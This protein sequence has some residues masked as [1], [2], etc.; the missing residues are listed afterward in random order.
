MTNWKTWPECVFFFFFFFLS[1]R[2]VKPG[3][4]T[5]LSSMKHKAWFMDEQDTRQNTEL[6]KSVVESVL[7]RLPCLFMYILT[8]K[9]IKKLGKKISKENK[10]K[11]SMLLN[12]MRTEKQTRAAALRHTIY[13]FSLIMLPHQ[14]VV[15][16]SKQTNHSMIQMISQVIQ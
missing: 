9:F 1:S 7:L 13:F 3:S 10:L 8:T 2:R 11:A 15:T 4:V 14:H 16:G 12:Q 6:K 5:T